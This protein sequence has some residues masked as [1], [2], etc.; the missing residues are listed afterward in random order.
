[1]AQRRSHRS[2]TPGK[3]LALFRERLLRFRQLG[4]ARTLEHLSRPALMRFHSGHF[5]LTGYGNIVPRVPGTLMP[6]QMAAGISVRI[7]G[8]RGKPVLD[9]GEVPMVKAKYT[10]LHAL[11]VL[12]HKLRRARPCVFAA[13]HGQRE[14]LATSLTISRRCRVAIEFGTRRSGRSGGASGSITF[15]EG[16]IPRRELWQLILRGES[17]T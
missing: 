1:M 5:V 13:Q 6:A 10:G 7:L 2:N 12:R 16:Q 8:G 11:I 4:L 15:W 14:R 17:S 9:E 3:F